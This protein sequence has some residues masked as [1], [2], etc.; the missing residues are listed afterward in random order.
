M[1]N[2]ISIDNSMIIPS[3]Y[4]NL[5]FNDNDNIIL[6]AGDV[7]DVKVLMYTR[8]ER[9]NDNRSELQNVGVFMYGPILLAGMTDGVYFDFDLNKIEQIVT[10]TLTLTLTITLTFTLTLTSGMI[11]VEKKKL[12]LWK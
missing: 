10:L 2:D 5:G 12:L 11:L 9:L 8:W 7:I 3:S 1:V 4:L 6:K